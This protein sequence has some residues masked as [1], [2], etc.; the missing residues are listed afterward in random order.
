[1]P[2]FGQLDVTEHLPRAPRVAK[3]ATAT[4]EFAVDK[5]TVLSFTWE[6]DIEQGFRVTPKALHP[7]IPSYCQVIFRAHPDSPLG[8]FTTAELRVNAR[9]GT[10]YLGYCIGTLTDSPRAAEYLR[11]R[12]GV[13]VREADVRVR[14][15]YHGLRGSVQFDDRTLFDALLERPHYISGSDVL[16]TPNLNLAHV[17]GV[18]KLV[19]QEMEYTLGKAERGRTVLT[20]FDAEGFG[21]GR[22]VLR[23]PLPATATEASIRYTAVHYLLDPDKPA[24][25]GTEVLA[26]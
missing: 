18:P 17:D 22:V 23:Q 24:L 1:M 13:H 19:H 12:Y 16:Y 2:I 5:C 21:D 14:R 4:D 8:A 15:M 11:T 3:L 20:A 26:A 25:A 6:I 7:S 9:A 10:N